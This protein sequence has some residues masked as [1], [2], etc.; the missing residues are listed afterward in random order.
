MKII[1]D[2]STLWSTFG[3]YKKSALVLFIVIIV[4]ALTETL[5]LWVILPL[6][7]IIINSSTSSDSSLLITKFLDFFPAKQHLFVVCGIAI[8]LIVLKSVFM[9]LRSYC[10]I[11]FTTN[12]RRYWSGGIMK[13]YM[14]S[15][16]SVL[17]RQK[18][19]TLMNNMINEPSFASKALRDMIDFTARAIVS[20]FIIILLFTV[21]WRISVMLL[22]ISVA[23]AL[24]VWRITHK[25]SFAVGK[26]KIK[27]NQQ[28]SGIA[29]ESIAG[30]R[31]IK[32]FS[33]EK[34][35]VKEFFKK[36][37]YLFNLIVKFSV[38]SNLPRS[39][40]E[41]IVIISALGVLMFY[42][43]ALNVEITSILP[44][45]GFFLIS[46]QKL[47]TNLSSLLSQRMSIVSYIPSLKL[48]HTIINDDSALEE[49]HNGDRHGA[50]KKDLQI[51]HASFY[52]DNGKPLFNDL[53]IEIPKGRITAVA[54]PSGSG[55]STICDL[56][57]G[58]Y[59]PVSGRILVDGRDLKEFN[60]RSWRNAIGYISQDSF[61]FN[62]SVRE[63]IIIGK[64]GA[65][66][67]EVFQ[68]AAQAGAS[69][70]IEAL[71]GKYDTILGDSGISLSGGQKQRIA[72]ARA[73][74]RNPELLIFDEATS[75]LDSETE[76]GILD[77]LKSL[78]GKK[79]ILF[80]SHRLSSLDFADRIYVLDDGS[81]VE[82]GNYNDLLDKKGLFWKLEQIARKKPAESI[83]AGSTSL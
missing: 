56:L 83:E 63:N 14:Y 70:F 55:K 64:P 17:V 28:I 24:A 21:N 9:V 12:L 44:L 7:D 35:V 65:G 51:S 11:K 41:I 79:T 74:I 59:S 58:F 8:F 40:G 54:G 72:I 43:Y 31:Q 60:I 50:I 13:N 29:A 57:I 27:F 4:S 75:S 80:I 5:S 82:S 34:Y 66:D 69:E 25:Y 36:M 2:I 38:V 26:K 81:V 53:N 48:V 42:K 67:D 52:Y 37:D 32:T 62:I 46:A 76:R 49:M 1:S 23:I 73:L 15:R 39:F 33:M 61:L 16:F 71:P 77:L 45:M 30:V 19:G 22:I 6:L 68:A 3:N 78:R 47:F 18:Q 10:S 20:L